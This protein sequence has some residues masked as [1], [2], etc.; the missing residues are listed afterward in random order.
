MNLKSEFNHRLSNRFTASPW[1]GP[2]RV[3]QVNSQELL[4]VITIVDDRASVLVVYDAI[5]FGLVIKIGEGSDVTA[6]AGT[7]ADLVPGVTHRQVPAFTID[8][9][10][11]TTSFRFEG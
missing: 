1:H 2:S 9:Q 10:F 5:R 4:D 6:F 3:V 8:V 11:K 7:I